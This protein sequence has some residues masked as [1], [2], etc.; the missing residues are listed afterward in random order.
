[1]TEC[2]FYHLTVTTGVSDNAVHNSALFGHFLPGVDAVNVCWG[3]CNGPPG[4]ILAP[5]ATNPC[6]ALRRVDNPSLR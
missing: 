2:S 4:Q 6:A 3:N 1:M 5:V